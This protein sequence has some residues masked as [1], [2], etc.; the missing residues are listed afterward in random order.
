MK[1]LYFF[2]DKF[3]VVEFTENIHDTVIWPRDSQSQSQQHDSLT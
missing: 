2:N 3:N 1:P